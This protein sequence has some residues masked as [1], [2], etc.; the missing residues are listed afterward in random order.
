M[1]AGSTQSL[2][3][4]VAERM[5]WYQSLT[6]PGGIVTPGGF[7]TA[8]ELA[9]VPF[10]ASLEGR[11]C[12]D[13]GTAEGFWA[14]EMEK[15]GAAEVV[16]VDVNEAAS[17]DLPGDTAKGPHL[18]D[19]RVHLSKFD[20]A[21]EALGSNVQRRNL[22]VYE[23]NP[24]VVGYFDFVFMGSLLLHLKDPVAALTAICGVLRG[25]MLSVDAVSPPLTLLHPAQPVARLEASALPLWWVMNL[26]AYQRLFGAAGLEILAS[27]RP[28]WVKQGRGYRESPRHRRSPYQRIR[29][30]A[31]SRFGVLH[32]WVRAQPLEGAG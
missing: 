32:A 31:V 26:Q 30:A 10:P 9:R 6:L 24:D 16:A 15:R 21:H 13:V 12:L 25:E 20:I 8:A 18:D 2:A 7:D 11:R 28:F 19:G 29:R 23:L 1:A 5:P 14:Y 3:E 4:L 22:T 17:Y 27:G